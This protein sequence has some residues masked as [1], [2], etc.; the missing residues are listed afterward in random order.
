M[1]AVCD[2]CR[3]TGEIVPGLMQK[4]RANA[5]FFIY[6]AVVY[7]ALPILILISIVFTMENR[8]ALLHLIA[9]GSNHSGVTL[10]RTL[11]VS[12][13]AVWK[14]L[15]SL[16]RYDLDIVHV[17]GKGYRLSRAIEL[18]DKEKILGALPQPAGAAV[19]E[20]TI[21]LET[22]STNRY[23]MNMLTAGGIHGKIVLSEF[24]TSG[25][26]RRGRSWISP[27]GSGI[28]VSLGWRFELQPASLTALSLAAG[29]AVIEALKRF[30]IEDIGLKWPND[31]VCGGAKLGG[32][33]I[34]TRGES[35]GAIDVVVGIGINVDVP[36]HITAAIDQPVTDL[37]RA[38][39]TPIS[40]NAV[41]AALISEIVT[42]FRQ[43]AVSGFSGFIESWREYD[44]VTGQEAR[45]ILPNQIL[46]GR[47]EGIDQHG[48]LAMRIAGETR[49]FSSGDLS[50]RAIE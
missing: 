47:V 28:C 32:I 19:K 34:E 7:N 3:A 48:M 13:T 42:M 18:F 8:L 37:A 24:Q 14:H 40:R 10:A 30:D 38:A 6:R 44:T 9:D 17:R 21:L 22:E 5:R 27:L 43:F 20:L 49:T 1:G 4:R 35:A 16:A 15:N 50:L 12:R 41:T 45:L 31:I 25:R 11:G 26:G 23:L 33:L 2:R 29:V 39:A 46:V 36:D